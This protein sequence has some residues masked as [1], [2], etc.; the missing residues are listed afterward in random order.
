MYEPP[1]F[2]TANLDKYEVFTAN[3]VNEASTDCRV[4]GVPVFR[5]RR[6]IFFVQDRR[7]SVVPA[8]VAETRDSQ[9]PQLISTRL[10]RLGDI[11]K[12]H[13]PS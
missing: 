3:R 5:D 10:A 1:T 12:S 13:R 6:C 8:D 7:K 2:C 11:A 4:S 9:M